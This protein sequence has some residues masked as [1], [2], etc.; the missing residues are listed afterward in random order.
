M[1]IARA[2][3][4]AV[5]VAA[6]PASSAAASADCSPCSQVAPASGCHAAP[7]GDSEQLRAACCCAALACAEESRPS[8]DPAP[9][10]LSPGH[11]PSAIPPASTPARTLGSTAREPLE[12]G[13]PPRA[14]RVP[15]YTLHGSYLI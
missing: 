9:S 2:I 5:L 4:L 8:A 3:A 12:P 11:G 1:R 6:L 10:W 13:S 15:L 7:A 14:A